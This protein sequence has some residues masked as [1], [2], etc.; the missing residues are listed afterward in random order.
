MVGKLLTLREARNA[1]RVGPRKLD[2]LRKSGELEVIRLGARTIRVR[3]TVVADLLERCR[4][5]RAR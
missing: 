4:E 2:D 3:E 1:L 5:G